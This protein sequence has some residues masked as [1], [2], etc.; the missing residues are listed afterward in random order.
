[1]KRAAHKLKTIK[2][3][4]R[5]NNWIYFDTETKSI[6]KNKVLDRQALRLGYALH[7][8]YDKKNILQSDCVFKDKD[9]FNEYLVSCTRSN[10]ILN[11][12]SMNLAFDMT[13]CDTCYYLKEAGWTLKTLMIE[14][15]V[16][17]IKY[18]KGKASIVFV[19]LFNYVKS[20]VAQI[21]ELIG[22][23]K[24]DVDFKKV[25][26]KELLT[27]CKRDTEIVARMMQYYMQ[28]VYDNDLGCLGLTTSSQ[29]FNSY[30]HRFM[31]HDIF[32]H[33][34][35]G[36]SKLE[37]RSYFGGR[38][39]CFKLGRINRQIQVVDINS[40]YPYIM[41]NY[42]YPT[43]LVKT[44]THDCTIKKI[45]Q[46]IKKYIVIADCVINTDQPVYAI[47]RDKKTMFPVG[48][49]KV[50]LC[51][52]SLEYALKHK[53]IESVSMYALYEGEYI[54][55]EYVD[56]FYDMRLKH[57]KEDNKVWREL[58]KNFL[59]YL[60]GKFGQRMRDI[61]P[62]G[63][64]IENTTEIIQVFNERGEKIADR[65]IVAGESFLVI[66]K[67]E[68]GFNSF[69][70]IA[71]CVTD[72]ARMYLWELMN[73]AGK[74]NVYYTDTD[75]LF[76]NNTGLRNLK[77]VLHGSELGKM[78]HESTL[79]W[80]KING[81]KDYESDVKT[82]LKGVKKKAIKVGR[83]TFRQQQFPTMKGVIRSGARA[84]I[85]IKTIEKTLSRIYNKGDVDS[86]GNVTPFV[87][88]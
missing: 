76:V 55:K 64:W 26:D 3:T 14:S 31:K 79:K 16:T 33:N 78:G 83:N 51:Q 66:A 9:T 44:V 36:V 74:E 12:M 88:G 15:R 80:I 34:F 2:G 59:N 24:L 20:S 5:K 81:L 61:K 46:Q 37:R 32:I 35:E 82:A 77:D 27:Y 22:L 42:K 1:M 86:L 38:T 7:H 4:E 28:F 62:E 17:I 25:S 67:E 53:H 21:G 13:I 54:F 63:K 10:S 84:Y 47:K 58:D 71:S 11:V 41:R 6:K 49:F 39:E 57:T 73:L 65:I 43:K 75:S 8:R 56:Y 30:R 29:A 23:P 69:V 45:Q 60:Y 50:T 52:G 70:A 19:D 48:R 72:Y 87:L 40:M 85:D 18:R 68:E